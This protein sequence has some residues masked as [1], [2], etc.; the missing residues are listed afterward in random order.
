MKTKF[1]SV[2]ALCLMSVGVTRPAN[3]FAYTVT[4]LDPLPGY[5]QSHAYGI[6]DAGQVVGYSATDTNLVRSATIWNG[7]TPTNI[8]ALVG[9]TYNSQAT[10]INNAG[11]IVGAYGPLGGVLGLGASFIQQGVLWSGNTVTTLAP[12]PGLTSSYA[13]AINNAGQVV[14]ISYPPF[15]PPFQNQLATIW[16]GA[17]PTALTT[18]AGLGSFAYGINNS[19]H[20]VGASG[21]AVIWNNGIPTALGVL[22]GSVSS[23]AT[24]INNSG[25]VIGESYFTGNT[26]NWEATIW[27]GGVP[28]ELSILSGQPRNGISYANA[29]NDA[30]LVV[31]SSANY[32]GL[33][34]AAV[35]WD[36]GTPIK[37]GTLLDSSGAGWALEDAYAI[38]LV[39]QIAGVGL[40]DGALQAFLLELLALPVSLA[41]PVPFLQLP[42][43]P[44]SRYLHRASA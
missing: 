5:G 19:G 4:D 42:S 38:N 8:G 24:A 18:P 9:T 15:L 7:S 37:L 23:Y 11:Q 10:A 1:V 39:G 26:N 6:N 29:I 44:L 41:P 40:Y 43:Q 34:S 36:D 3:A 30:G 21:N 35:L 31:G 17:T 33:N 14:G 16:N 2:A 22:P 32:A 27:N 13:T 20:V 12:L 25:K 28:T